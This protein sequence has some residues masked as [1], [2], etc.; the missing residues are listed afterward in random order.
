MKKAFRLLVVA[1]SSAMAFTLV[2]CGGTTSTPATTSKD[3]GTTSQPTTSVEPGKAITIEYSGTASNKTFNQVLFEDFKAARAAAGDKNTYTIN[4]VEHG[5]DKIDSEV[6]DWT[7][8]PDVYE[9]AAD[10][11]AG[12]FKAGALAKVSGEFKTY[13]EENI[14]KFG[15][16][17]ATFN[18]EY[19]AYAYTG[20]NTYYLQYD[21]SVL[22]ADDVSSM[23]KLL[24]KAATLGKKVGYNLPE[25]F[26]G[27][28]AMFTFG[29]DYKI[30]YDADGVVQSTTADFDGAK[31]I[32]AAKAI[33]KIVKD[34]S[35]TKTM[36][37]PTEA[38]GLV[39]CMAGTWDIANYKTALGDNYGCAVMPTVT[40]D[41]T[42]KH[43]G[44]F[45]GGKLF[46]VNPAKGDADKL[47]AAH[48][49]AEYLSG[50]EAQ[51]KRFA[52]YQTAPCNIAAAADATVKANANI[53]VLSEQ[54]TFAHAQT[55]V[56]GN[57]WSAPATLING[58]IDGTVTEENLAAACKTFN[59]SVIASK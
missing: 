26:W 48:R 55:S 45:L 23:E 9:F 46:G 54:G 22:S 58:M 16:D 18:D 19:Y 34:A 30:V 56:P 39:A 40:V 21:K 37:P 50:K 24:A 35:W 49:L 5:P 52:E 25:G 7:T 8:G 2:S 13:I 31:G 44:A 42:T 47:V 59:D 53:A 6:T 14:N 12:L 51:L 32:A 1:A 15:Q 29:A 10:K 27:G 57:F 38:N 3:D 17:A 33:M 20:D 4:Y 11:L 41:G 36:E 28:A 43:L